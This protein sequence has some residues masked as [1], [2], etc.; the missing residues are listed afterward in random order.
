MLK[1]CRQA[2]DEAAKAAGRPVPTDAQATAI[3]NMLSSQMSRLAREDN[4]RWRTLTRDQQMTEAAKA[5][6]QD[7]KAQA[8]RKLDNAERQVVKIAE[9]ENRITTLQESFAGTKGHD[10]TRAEAWKR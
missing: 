10:G 3:E 5:A 1:K 8:Q 6:I 9:T 7:I 4:A 2:I